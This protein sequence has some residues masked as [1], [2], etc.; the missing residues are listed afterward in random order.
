MRMLVSDWLQLTGISLLEAEVDK[1]KRNL[2]GP[3][4][5]L[6]YGVAPFLA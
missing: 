2:K 1:H 6:T 5:F 4:W 3:L